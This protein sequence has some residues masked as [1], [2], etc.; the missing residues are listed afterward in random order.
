M[1]EI[2]GMEYELDLGNGYYLAFSSWSP[3]RKINP[4]YDNVPD[5]ENIGAVVLCSHGNRA[6]L[7]FKQTDPIYK[8]IFSD[9]NW[10]DLISLEPLHV[11]PSIQ[12]LDPKCCHG[13]IREGKWVIA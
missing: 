11:E 2:N 6:G 9:S 13:Y 8:D 10:W 7:M 1:I 5:V 4:Q 12:F 3:D